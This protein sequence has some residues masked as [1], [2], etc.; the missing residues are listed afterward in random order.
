[1]TKT[2]SSKTGER[3]AARILPQPESVADFKQRIALIMRNRDGSGKVYSMVGAS[4][5]PE[6]CVRQ[7]GSAPTPSEV[8]G[9]AK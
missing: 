5:A 7:P 6:C 1:M 9:G 2:K 4:R 8:L 3:K